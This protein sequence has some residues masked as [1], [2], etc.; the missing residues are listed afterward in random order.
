MTLEVLEVVGK[1]NNDGHRFL[2]DWSADVERAF[3]HVG[4]H[5]CNCDVMGKR[6]R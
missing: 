1:T 2:E 6:D 4:G 5:A 3:P